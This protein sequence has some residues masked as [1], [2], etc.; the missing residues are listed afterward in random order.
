MTSVP[1]PARQLP[2]QNSSSANSIWPSL[3]GRRLLP[4][5]RSREIELERVPVRFSV[6][7]YSPVSVL[8]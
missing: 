3:P 7:T 1:V 2:R 6:E 5:R 8:A 4:A